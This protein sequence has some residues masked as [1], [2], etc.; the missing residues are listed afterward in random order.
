MLSKSFLYSTT[1]GTLII[2]I[3][4]SFFSLFYW[5]YSKKKSEAIT[6]IIIFLLL[7]AFAFSFSHSPFYGSFGDT[8]TQTVL[9]NLLTSFVILLTITSIISSSDL[10]SKNLKYG[11]YYFLLLISLTSS[12]LLINTQNIFNMFISVELLSMSLYGLT[13]FNKND[14]NLE[15]S[16]KYFMLGSFASVFM[17]LSLVFLYIGLGSLSLVDIKNSLAI[18]G[19]NPYIN[20]GMLLFMS[21]FIFK[22]ALVPMHSWAVDVYWGAPTNV[23]MFMISGVKLSIVVALYRLFSSYTTSVVIYAMYAF[24]VLSIVIP[25]LIA[26]YSK[27]IKK[28]IIYSSISHAGYIAISFLGTENWQA[29]F[30]AIIYSISVIGV[31]SVIMFLEKNFKD[32]NYENIKG[33]YHSKPSIAISLLIFLFS[34]SGVPPFSGFFA[35]FYSFYN[36]VN[37]G[38]KWLVVIA[39]LTSALSLYYYLKIL[40]PAFMKDAEK[41]DYEGTVCNYAVIYLT[42]AATLLLGILSNPIIELIK[43]SI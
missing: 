28:I 27:D 12:I 19:P 42:A 3:L 33:L 34:L 13:G 38:F 40:I 20:I 21:G 39:V 5:L 11:E 43:N 9:N 25:N 26:L 22:L 7:F 4:S 10:M 36:A 6:E 18:S 31:F 30:Y 15:A 32:L 29:Y 14:K 41:R 16:F 8:Y 17:I 24:I 1:F 35:K 2:L 23:S 37:G